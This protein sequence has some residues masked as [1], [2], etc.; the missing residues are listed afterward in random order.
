M[1]LFR[2]SWWEDNLQTQETCLKNMPFEPV[3]NSSSGISPKKI[4]RAV[5]NRSNQGDSFQCCSL[6]QN[7]VGEGGLV[8]PNMVHPLRKQLK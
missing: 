6:Q 3:S 8:K 7:L 5:Q 2:H 1:D 4:I